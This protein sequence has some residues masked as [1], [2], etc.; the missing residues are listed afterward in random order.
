[1]NRGMIMAPAMPVI[2]NGKIAQ[3]ELKAQDHQSL[4]VT[5]D[6]AS[7]Y[8]RLTERHAWLRLWDETLAPLFDIQGVAAQPGEFPLSREQI[9]ELLRLWSYGLPEQ[10]SIPVNSAALL[11]MGYAQAPGLLRATRVWAR[12]LMHPHP[13]SQ[14][15]AAERCI[16]QGFALAHWFR[17]WG[18]RD[19]EELELLTA[20]HAVSLLSPEDQSRRQQL[21][22]AL[23]KSRC[24][25]APEQPG[26]RLRIALRDRADAYS[27]ERE[28]RESPEAARTLLAVRGEPASNLGGALQRQHWTAEE[29]F[30][31]LSG[32]AASRASVGDAYQLTIEPVTLAGAHGSQDCTAAIFRS[33]ASRLTL[34]LT[35]DVA[36]GAA[37]IYL[38]TLVLADP[39]QTIDDY[40]QRVQTV[41]AEGKQA[42][43]TNARSNILEAVNKTLE[44]LQQAGQRKAPGG[45]VG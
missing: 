16:Q 1:M 14:R 12:A 25:Q 35:V 19:E 36:N 17:Q 37:A 31:V 23:W 29:F 41:Q 13:G 33:R 7:F 3:L 21:E 20:L 43:E 40:I 34:L 5:Q 44:S 8:L 42:A 22:K 38:S 28:F 39:G 11:L 24:M 18:S 30:T 2:D 6:A 45:L 15:Q 10:A 26:Q 27:L 32:H 9:K 4:A